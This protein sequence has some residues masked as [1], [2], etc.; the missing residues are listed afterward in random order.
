[1]II[2]Y[3]SKTG[4]TKKYADMLA[5]KTKLKAYRVKELPESVKDEEIIFLG[6]LKAGKI[7]GLGKARKYNVK[8][9]CASGTARTAEP[10]EE[11]VIARNKVKGI[12]FFY[13]RGGC[14]P[15][16]EL[17]GMDKILMSMFLKILKSRKEKDERINE[18]ISNI[19]NGFDGV[20]EENLE[21]VL[22]W[23]DKNK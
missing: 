7:Q 15:L 21:P 19:V 20:R 1:M 4:F 13:L 23:L 11:T 3:E 6:W 2:V 5:E 16:K 9:V 12:P 17:K 18:A 14:L 10:D 22:K 8:A